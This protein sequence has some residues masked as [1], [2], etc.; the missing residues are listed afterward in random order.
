MASDAKGGR[1]MNKKSWMIGL[2]SAMVLAQLGAPIWMIAQSEWTLRTGRLFRF[3]TAPVDPYDAFRGRFV[4][5]RIE[6]NTAP[7]PPGISLEPNQKVYVRL[8][9]DDRGFARIESLSIERPTDDAYLEATV[10]NPY[11]IPVALRFPFD[12]YYLQENLA[13]KAEKAYQEHSSRGV[14]DAYI[15][16]RVQAG[17][18]EIEGLYIGDRRIDDFLRNPD[19]SSKTIEK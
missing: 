3:H 17:I 6:P 18:A 16:V 2:F 15:T 1:E 13:P 5:L 14:R 4:A 12:R 10:M 19:E 7:A 9:E 8:T 11:G